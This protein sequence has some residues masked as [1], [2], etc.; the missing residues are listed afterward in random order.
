MIHNLL[1]SHTHIHQSDIP[2]H[3]HPINCAIRKKVY[4][5]PFYTL[6][7]NQFYQFDFASTHNATQHIDWSHCGHGTPPHKT[8]RFFSFETN[9]FATMTCW[10]SFQPQ[11][12]LCSTIR[13]L[14][15]KITLENKLFHMELPQ[16]CRG[17][18]MNVIH[19]HI[20]NTFYP[21]VT[22]CLCFPAHLGT[23]NPFYP[24]HKLLSP[25]YQLK[26]HNELT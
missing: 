7:F 8:W 20:S 26:V 4:K 3:K 14:L 1:S 11:R 18:D 21:Q 23:L 13:S 2:Y 6:F 9:S 22:S 25:R 17:S 19:Q 12:P 16:S 15:S 5:N 10:A 24:F